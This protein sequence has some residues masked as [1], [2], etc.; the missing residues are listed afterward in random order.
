[1]LDLTAA[2]VETGVNV[3]VLTIICTKL[4]VKNMYVVEPGQFISK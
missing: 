2:F 1:M 3:T 4:F